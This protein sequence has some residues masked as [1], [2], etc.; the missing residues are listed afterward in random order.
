MKELCQPD[1]KTFVVS[2]IPNLRDKVAAMIPNCPVVHRPDRRASGQ[3]HKETAEK[4]ESSIGIGKPNER[5]LVGNRL[6]RFDG[7]G[8]P[9]QAYSLGNNHHIVIWESMEPNKKGEYERRAEIV[10]TIEAVQRRQKRESVIRK[11]GGPE[12]WRFVMSLCKGDMVEMEHGVVGV[13]A[14]FSAEANSGGIYLVIWQPYVAQK[15]GTVNPQN[16]Y[17]IQS[18]RSSPGLRSIRFRTVRSIFGE[19]VYSEGNSD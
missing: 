16:P 10:P 19:S 7:H 2:P 5:R 4:P 6:V 17:L 14:K 18:V 15:L 3:L 8:K 12:G 11:C 1:S 13:V 9:A